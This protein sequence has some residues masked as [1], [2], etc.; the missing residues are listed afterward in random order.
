[1]PAGDDRENLMESY[2]PVMNYARDNGFKFTGRAH[3]I[4]FSTQRE[5]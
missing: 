1:M 4:A 5:V 2:G 3:I